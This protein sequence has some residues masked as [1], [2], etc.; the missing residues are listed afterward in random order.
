MKTPV[1]LAAL[2]AMVAME[3]SAQE[4]L[5]ITYGEAEFLNSCAACHGA[6]GKGNGPLAGQLAERPADLTML[7]DRN[8]G[9]FPFDRVIAIIDGRFV[10]PGHGERDMPVWGRQF[11]EQDTEDFGAED[12]EIVTSVRM[13]ELADYLETLQR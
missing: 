4:A 1:V 11:L 9:R 13:R 6:D 10:V 7:S 2:F 8:G 12:A 3:C 5:E